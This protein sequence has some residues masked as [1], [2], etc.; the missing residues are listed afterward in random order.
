MAM[1]VAAVAH[2]VPAHFAGLLVIIKSHR[3]FRLTLFFTHVF[4]HVFYC[5]I[6]KTLLY[7]IR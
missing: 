3:A 7:I 5:L 6:V 1:A 4:V 2:P